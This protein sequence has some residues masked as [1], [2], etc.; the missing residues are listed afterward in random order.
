MRDHQNKFDDLVKDGIRWYGL[1]LAPS[2][3]SATATI[4]GAAT[5]DLALQTAGSIGSFVGLASLKDI[6]KD[7]KRV[8]TEASRLRRSATGILFRTGL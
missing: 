1:K 5:G 3:I 4:V 6:V 7:G 2:I 8:V